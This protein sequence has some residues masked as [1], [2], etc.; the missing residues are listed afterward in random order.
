MCGGVSAS[1]GAVAILELARADMA[2][3]RSSDVKVAGAISGESPEGRRRRLT[4]VMS[5]LS[6]SASIFLKEAQ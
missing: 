2:I 5:S 4:A 3:V 6:T 1:R